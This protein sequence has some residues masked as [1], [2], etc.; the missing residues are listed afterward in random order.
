LAVGEL[1]DDVAAPPRVAAD[2]RKLSIEETTEF[3]GGSAKLVLEDGLHICEIL[4]I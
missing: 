1:V 3:R 2:A 4:A